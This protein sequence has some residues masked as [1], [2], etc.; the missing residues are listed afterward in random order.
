MFSQNSIVDAFSV[1]QL[2][3]AAMQDV[4]DDITF[5]QNRE[6][7]GHHAGVTRKL[8]MT[9]FGKWLIYYKNDKD[10]TVKQ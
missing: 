4:G 5:T 8:R 1:A 9:H 7:I 3:G 6:E 2:G 10:Y